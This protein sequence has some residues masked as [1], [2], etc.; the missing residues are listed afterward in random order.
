MTTEDL[1]PLLRKHPFCEG[2][3]P[4]RLAFLAGCAANVRYVHGERIAQHDCAAD[5]VWLIRAGRVEVRILGVHT[6]ATVE[7]GELFGWSSLL[8]P[9][10]WHF[11]A[12]AIGPVRALRI[13]ASCLR[14][15]CE[16]DSG[17]GYDIALR[18][19]HQAQRAL[20]QARVHAL[21]IYGNGG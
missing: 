14:G 13:D 8:E 9:H 1:Q 3:A 20:E 4:E 10:T 18:I 5:Y 12:V 7:E 6:V 19:L 2:M 16:A 21:D 15:K 17:F 11:D